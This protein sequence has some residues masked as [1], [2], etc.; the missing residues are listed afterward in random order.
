MSFQ[1]KRISICL[2]LI[3]NNDTDRNAYIQ[4][5]LQQ[6]RARLS[7]NF[8]TKIL[9]VSVQP[10]IKPQS[11]L[12]IFLRDVLYRSLDRE[13]SR[14]RLLKVRLLPLDVLSFMVSSFRKYAFSWGEK[15]F[16]VS[17]KR[18]GFVETLITDKHIRVWNGFLESCADFLICFEDDAVFKDESSQRVYELLDNLS[19]RS[20]N[21]QIYV[22]LAGGC[23]HGDL[24]VDNL[25]MG[26]DAS[27]RFYRKPVTNTACSYLMSRPLVSIFI[28]KLIRRPWLRLIGVDWL[29]NKL[30][31]IA[32]NDGAECACMHAS[33]TIFNH[34]S[35]TGEYVSRNIEKQ[36]D[37]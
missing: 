28:E 3:H 2:A 32:T 23:E 4:P 26:K 36:I 14:Y 33:P 35:F 21:R 5:A 27:F 16:L 34:G 24:K 6:L 1:Q 31:I 30:F 25:E 11:T 15:S 13:W 20:L 22:D 12:M 7:Q 8:T 18:N 37:V 19:R 10:K 9:E 17:L 29:M